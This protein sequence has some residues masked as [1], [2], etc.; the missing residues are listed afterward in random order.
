MMVAVPKRSRETGPKTALVPEFVDWKKRMQTDEAKA[1]FRARPGHREWTNA[2]GAGR[3]G[4][5]QFLVR[6]IAK[7]T[8]VYLLIAKL[9]S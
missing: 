8:S 9:A 3:I 5:R 7:A 1:L 2:Q 6:G 4:L